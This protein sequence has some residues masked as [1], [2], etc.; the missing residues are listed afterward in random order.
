VGVKYE[1]ESKKNLV[2]RRQD[3]GGDGA[4]ENSSPDGLR[5]GSK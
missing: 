5:L 2:G 4:E 3:D 1:R